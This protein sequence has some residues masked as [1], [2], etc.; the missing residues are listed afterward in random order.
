MV[1]DPGVTFRKFS[2]EEEARPRGDLCLGRFL[3]SCGN[4]GSVR[5]NRGLDLVPSSV[6]LGSDRGHDPSKDLSRRGV[7]IFSRARCLGVNPGISGAL[8]L[9]RSGS[10]RG[11]SRCRLS[12]L[13]CPRFLIN[14]IFGEILIAEF[15]FLEFVR[16]QFAAPRVQLPIR[17]NTLQST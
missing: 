4:L 7:R 13:L 5:G 2:M 14:S 17:S 3:S 9:I 1:P 12:A 15:V 16:I 8:V 6:I 10:G 11:L